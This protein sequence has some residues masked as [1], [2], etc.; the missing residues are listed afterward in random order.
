MCGFP[1]D[2]FYYYQ[3]NWTLKPVLHLFPHWNWST[4]GQPINVWAFGNC[5]T[6][7]LFTNGV[8]LGRQALNVQGHVEW[9]N[10]PYAAG[11]LKAIGYNNGVAVITNTVVTTGTPAAIALIPD[12]NTI[13]ADGHDVSVVTV[14]VLDAQGR[15]MP[16]AT[17]LVNFTVSG[18]AII[19]VGNGD[20]SSHE[21]DKGSSQ[22]SVFN[23]LAEVIVQSINQPGTITLTATSTGLTSTNITITEASSLPAPA[24]PTGVAAGAGNTQVTVTWDV[25]P[26]ATT[27]NLWRATTS[28][29]PY[30]LLAGNIGSLNLGYTD[31]TVANLTRYYYVVTANG[32]GASV[33]SAEVNALPTTFVTNLTATATNG[34]IVLTW[35]GSPGA[36]YNVKRSYVT[37]GPYNIIASSITGTNYTDASVVSCQSYF[38]VVTIT[39]AGYESLP[40]PE[41]GAS[42]PGG[43]LPSPW[44][45]TDIGAVGLPGSATYCNGQFTILGSGADI[46]LTS[47]EFQFVYYYVPV[48]TN[49]DIRARVVSVVQSTAGNAKAAVMIRETLAPDSRHALVDV[50]PT[51]GI[52]FLFRTN[53]TSVTTVSS[54]TGQAPNWVRLTR[55]NNTFTAYWS[56]D[57]NAWTQIGAPTNINMAVGAYIG[58]A[59][60]AHDNTQLN[61]SVIDNVSASFL[62]H[63]AP[64]LA[65]ISNQTVNVGQTVALTAS[66]TDT[67]TPPQMLTF[68]L[69][70]GP[71][72]AT[73]TQINNT[74][75][76]FS[77]R[78][79]VA[80]ANTTNPIT[81]EV[82]DYGLPGL[83]ATQ[84]FT[85]TVNPLALPTVPSVGWNNG[86]FKMLVTNS[87]VGP[88]YAVQASSNLVNWSTRFITNSPP[89]ASFQW[90]DTNALTLPMQFYRIKIGPPLP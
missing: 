74:N 69:L 22:R 24:A 44:L 41:A 3:A 17:N 31:N 85:I 67:N 63:T 47:D 88:D 37:G 82:E 12:R 5:Q 25:V 19:G 62:P 45:N 90:T 80:N 60:C 9:D 2:I 10:V 79:G 6:V 86:Q 50:E 1:K 26:G 21:A 29:G 53:T 35:N 68:N 83:S 16:I 59:V 57:G 61:T 8:S 38:Y 84:S 81:V 4:P 30:T 23:G 71:A 76:G 15:V 28:G 39:N 7:E 64:V 52:E 51:A 13:L 58:L 27:Y 48:S 73:L 70:S 14:E 66:A 56:P 11:T 42:G 55:T 65:A 87:I 20:P 33:K 77:W 46:W 43:A 18:G 40:S 36:T 89:T 54:V 49:C 78:P 32:N 72:S 34:Q 75:A